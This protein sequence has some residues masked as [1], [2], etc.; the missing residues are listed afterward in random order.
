MFPNL[1]RMRTMKMT[2]MLLSLTFKLLWKGVVPMVLMGQMVPMGTMISWQFLVWQTVY[3]ILG[4]K[5]YILYYV[6]I[7]SQKIHYGRFQK[8]LFCVKRLV[9]I[10]ISVSRRCSWS[11][12]IILFMHLCVFYTI[13]Q[14]FHI[15]FNF[16]PKIV[17]LKGFKRHYFVLKDLSLSAYWCQNDAYDPI[18]QTSI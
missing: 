8:A 15:N 10:S 14:I 4:K 7:Y 5:K 12:E 17:T 9:T 13:D 18:L 3:V 1:M 16:S 6:I 11:N 2:L